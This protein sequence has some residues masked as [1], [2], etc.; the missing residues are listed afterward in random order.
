MVMLCLANSA[1]RVCSPARRALFDGLQLRPMLGHHPLVVL[2]GDGRQPLGDQVVHGVAAF[3]LDHVALFA[4]V[5]DGLDQ[6]QLDAAV[7]PLGSR[8]VRWSRA[9]DLVTLLGAWYL[10]NRTELQIANCKFQIC[11]L[12]FSI[13]CSHSSSPLTRDG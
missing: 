3:D 11:N 9:G 12:Q 8:L 7:G 1:A 10:R 6:Q 4:Q 2:R 5:F 13:P